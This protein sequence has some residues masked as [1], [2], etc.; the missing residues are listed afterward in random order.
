MIRS[1]YRLQIRFAHLDYKSIRCCCRDKRH[2]F[3]IRQTSHTAAGAFSVTNC[4]WLNRSVLV[5]LSANQIIELLWESL[6]CRFDGSRFVLSHK[7]T[8]A[9]MATAT[10]DMGIDYGR[11]WPLYSESTTVKAASLG[12]ECKIGAKGN[13]KSHNIRTYIIIQ[14]LH[15][16]T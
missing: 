13:K 3:V 16:G 7:T 11:K 4:Q 8:T 12:F 6:C 10:W 15:Q 1:I 9:G 2:L 5:L 14:I